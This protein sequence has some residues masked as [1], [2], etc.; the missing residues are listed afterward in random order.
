MLEY[1]IAGIPC[2]IDVV[3]VDY[4][5][6]SYSYNAASDMDYYGYCEIEYTVRDRKGYLA[7]WLAGKITDEINEDIE[8]MILDDYLSKATD[9][10]EEYEAMMYDYD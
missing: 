10:R 3:S 4:S 9:A 8:R 2:L 7:P 6:G 5:P 1:R